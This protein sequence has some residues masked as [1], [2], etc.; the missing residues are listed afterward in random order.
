MAARMSPPPPAVSAEGL[1]ACLRVLA[2]EARSIGLSEA[3]FAITRAAEIVSAEAE[4]RGL[5]IG[6]AS[7][8]P[9]RLR[10][11]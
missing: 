3:A 4:E 8:R 6:G 11:D 10:P 7:G 2:E 5:T 9:R 1:F